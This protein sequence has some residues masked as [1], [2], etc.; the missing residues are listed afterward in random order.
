MTTYGRYPLTLVR[1]NGARVY[2]DQGREY[3][4]FVAGIAVN[5]LGH[6]HP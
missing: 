1:G 5:T 2:D 4:D 6:N 3:L